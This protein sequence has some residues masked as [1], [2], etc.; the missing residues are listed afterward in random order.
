MLKS[1]C[2]E[3]MRAYKEMEDVRCLGDV[4]FMLTPFEIG[5]LCARRITFCEI[6]WKI[7]ES[8]V[9]RGTARGPVFC[10]SILA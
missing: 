4:T 5:K 1:L 2:V 8:M 7:S 3:E 10:E 9:V 6:L